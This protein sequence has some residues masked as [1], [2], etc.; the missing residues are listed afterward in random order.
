[1]FDPGRLP[2]L[3]KR[4]VDLATD[5]GRYGYRRVTALLHREGWKVNHK[6]VERLWRQEG[7]KVPKKTTKTTK[8]VVERRK[9]HPAST[10]APRSCLEF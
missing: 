8:I 6:R 4:I 9:L 10:A 1:M 5:D 2:R 7:L 3:L